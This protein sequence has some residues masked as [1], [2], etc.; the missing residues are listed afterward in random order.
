MSTKVFLSLGQG[1]LSAGFSQIT[2]RLE[3]GGQLVA[4]QQGSLPSNLELQHL[5]RQW[6][7]Y[8]AAYYDHH[9]GD[10]R[11]NVPKIEIE[12][13]GVTGFSVTTFQETRQ[14]LEQEMHDWLENSSFDPISC[15]LR[16]KL[17]NHHEVVIIVETEDDCIHRL[18]WHYW[19]L[20]TD[21]SQAEVAFSLSTYQQQAYVSQ[22]VKPRIL[23]VF[24]DRTG[25]DTSAEAQLICQL[26]ADIISLTEPSR[27]TLSHKLNDPQGWDM[28]FFAGHGSNDAIDSIQLSVQESLTLAD[29]SYVLQSAIKRGLKLAIFN[30]CSGLGLATNLS[31]LNIPTVI[32]MREAIPNQVAQQFLQSFLGSF[33][34]GKSLLAAVGHARQQLQ[35]IEHNFPCATWLPVVFC[36]P[37]IELPTWQSFYRR[38]FRSRPKLW[39]VAVIALATTTG[40]W[41]IRSQG[42]LESVELAAYDLAM[43]TRLVAETPDERLLIVGITEDDFKHLGKNEPLRDRLIFQTLQK[44]Q[45][46]QP[47]AIGLDI[48]R[49]QPF[50]E[51]HLDLLQLLQQTPNSVVSSCLMPGEDAKSYPGVA[52]PTSVQSEQV[53][54][55]NFSTDRGAVVRRQVLGMAA[56]NQECGTDHALSLRLALKYL[57]VAEAQETDSG[58]IKVGA[59]ELEMLKS[60]VAAYR[61]V[62]AQENLRG[63]QIM[64]NYRHTP[65]IA[66]Q[67]SLADVL[68]DRV[69][70]AA[71]LGKVVLVGYVA[72]SAGDFFPTAYDSKYSKTVTEMPG[73][74]IHAH[75]VSNIL[76]HILDRRPWITT[77]SDAGEIAWIYMWGAV[78]GLIGWQRRSHQVWIVGSIAVVILVAIY[79]ICFNIWL[80]WIPLIPAGLALV[81]ML[82]MIQG[83]LKKIELS[84]TG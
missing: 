53:G 37:T 63:F 27:A 55:T 30:S 51:G 83:I 60:S 79:G 44:L 75:M 24:G 56:V 8:Y 65:T 17:N 68:S 66:K 3:S 74:W 81:L 9:S 11:E 28:L 70:S 31:T 77:W 18:P 41:G 26:P 22:R 72:P 48:Y 19:S 52:A 73:V 29:L 47:Q 62:A 7:F 20:I 16:S 64:L 57:G 46:H 23:A 10:L 50:G 80:V 67:V 35:A 32:V 71:I 76:S 45:K 5:Q 54:F 38:K 59:Q 36:N 25:L 21:F 82:L 78:G 33:A 69:D 15:Q 13:T 84:R 42:Y 6:Q 34:G 49:D 39:Q 61:S 43:N 4:Q 1:N 40:I 14:K 12:S 58:N 2:A